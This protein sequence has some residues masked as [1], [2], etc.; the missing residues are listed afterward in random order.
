[1]DTAPLRMEKA[2]DGAPIHA[3]IQIAVEV[4]GTESFSLVGSSRKIWEASTMDRT[5]EPVQNWLNQ[6]AHVM[7]R[8]SYMHITGINEC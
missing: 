1:M 5:W 2:P 7:T 4:V 3:S 8:I 6:E